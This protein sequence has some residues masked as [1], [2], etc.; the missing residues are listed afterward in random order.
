LEEA[1]VVS[2]QDLER[3]Y[4][5]SI[6]SGN[7]LGAVLVSEGLLT[8][9]YVDAA[10]EL[11]IRVRD[12]MFSR[13]QAIEA[14]RQD[15]RKLLELIAPF[16]MAPQGAAGEIEQSAKSA[17]KAKPVR[18]GELFVRAGILTQADVAQ[19][20]SWLWRI[21]IPSVRCLSLVPLSLERCLMLRSVCSVWSLTTSSQQAKPLPVWSKSLTLIKQSLS[22]CW[23]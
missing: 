7:P 20:L 23:S 10:L 22:V 5:Q 1:G 14:L 16:L 18:L 19:A 6:G 13:E 12:G 8:N 11:Q 4:H 9:S 17:A 15:P 2:A 21:H 3:A